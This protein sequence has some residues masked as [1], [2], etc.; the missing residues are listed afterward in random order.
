MTDTTLKNGTPQASGGVQSLERALDI[1]EVLGRSEGDL[2][3]SEVGTAVGLANGTVHRL[4]STLTNRGYARQNPLT[5]KYGLGL[6]AFELASS[7]RETLG[8][9]AR[10][11]LEELTEVS[12]ESSNLSGLDK[13]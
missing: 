4:L 12:R 10:P 9:L 6:R 2:G 11:C 13:N 3:V 5:R 8:P 1:L 7:A